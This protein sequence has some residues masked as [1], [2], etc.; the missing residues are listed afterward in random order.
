MVGPGARAT[1][2]SRSD[3]FLIGSNRRRND[4]V[5]GERQQ[6]GSRQGRLLNIDLAWVGRV[7]LESVSNLG[8]QAAK[9]KHARSEAEEGADQ[10]HRRG[11]R[12]GSGKGVA[13]RGLRR[14]DELGQ[15][16]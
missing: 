14:S 13:E 15:R 7:G 11:E 3:P 1:A 10:K 16:V 8:H 5:F 4:H 9:E 2:H 6:S 12:A